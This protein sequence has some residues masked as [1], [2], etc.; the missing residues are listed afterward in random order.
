MQ[1]KQSRT[2]APRSISDVTA[3]ISLGDWRMDVCQKHLML[4]WMRA[5]RGRQSRSFEER[6][7]FVFVELLPY[8]GMEGAAEERS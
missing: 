5:E 3:L 2:V 6:P 8:S 4:P 1:A 7:A